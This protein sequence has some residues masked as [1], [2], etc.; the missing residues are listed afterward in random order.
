MRGPLWRTHFFPADFLT[1]PPTVTHAR[2]PCRQLAPRPSQP[3]GM[4]Q[5]LAPLETGLSI[6]ARPFTP[7][8]LSSRLSTLIN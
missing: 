8:P 7:Y 3:A 4:P 6:N 2:L 1:L 5:R